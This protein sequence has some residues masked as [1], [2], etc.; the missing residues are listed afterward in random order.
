MPTAAPSTTPT[1]GVARLTVPRLATAP[2]GRASAPLLA[3]G[4]AIVLV[5]AWLAIAVTGRQALLFLVGT[6]AGLVLYHAAFGFTSAWRVFVSDRRGAGLRA[7]MLMLALTCCV[8]FPVLAAGSLGG[9][10]VRGAIAAPG[11][12][13]LAGAF[14]FGIG[15]QLGGGCASGTLYSAGGGSTRMFVVLAAFVAGS[16]IGTAHAP[17]WNALPAGAPTSIV[18]LW[19]PAFALAVSLAAFGGLAL[20]TVVVERGRHGRLVPPTGG[21]AHVLRGPWPL[22]A[23]AAGLAL[24][25]IAVLT[26]SG[27][28]WGVTSA[29]ALWGAKIA[30]AAGLPVASWPYWQAP[31]Q[32]AALAGPVAADVTSV[33]NLGIVLGALLAAILAGRLAPVWRVPARS[34]AA[35]VVGGLLLGYGARAASGCNIGAYFS[36]IASGSLHGWLWLPAAFV[37]SALGTRLRPWFG[38]AVERTT[39]C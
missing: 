6:A 23:G 8:F 39:S 11:L 37:G 35:A 15:M 9:Q 5:A 27:R 13:V 38:L 7:Q 22:A 31:A 19:G 36:G 34:L 14:V 32:A 33:V 12:G 17:W 26:L 28:P 21:P 10:P 16:L 30:A 1:V 25:N 18:Q 2:A 20:L 4:S 24:V 29:F 3:A